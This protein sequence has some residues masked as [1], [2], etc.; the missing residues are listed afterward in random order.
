MTYRNI[1][2]DTEPSQHMSYTHFPCFVLQKDCN[3]LTNK[4][5]LT[6]VVDETKEQ[7]D[8]LESVDMETINIDE[9][10]DEMSVL[11]KYQ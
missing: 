11:I 5:S 6:E 3:C 10:E 1:S 8:T 7:T 2:A 9:E 4:L